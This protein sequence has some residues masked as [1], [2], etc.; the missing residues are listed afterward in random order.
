MPI[1]AVT[2]LRRQSSRGGYAPR[3]GGASI[4]QADIKFQTK[5]KQKKDA[6]GWSTNSRSFQSD[7]WIQS[8]SFFRAKG[9]SAHIIMLNNRLLTSKTTVAVLIG[10]VPSTAALCASPYL[11]C[12]TQ[13]PLAGEVLKVHFITDDWYLKQAGVDTQVSV[14]C[15]A[16]ECTG[17]VFELYQDFKGVAGF[18]AV[19]TSLSPSALAVQENKGSMFTACAHDVGIGNLDLCVSNFW[20]TAERRFMTAF[21]SPFDLETFYLWTEK[22]KARTLTTM[23]A[24]FTTELWSTLALIFVLI[25]ATIYAFEYPAAKFRIKWR[26]R[27]EAMLEKG[28]RSKK[29][30]AQANKEMEKEDKEFHNLLRHMDVWGERDKVNTIEGKAMSILIGL[31]FFVVTACYTANL[32]TFLNVSQDAPMYATRAEFETE[33][34]TACVLT[35]LKGRVERS[36]PTLDIL[37]LPDWQSIKA[38]FLGGKCSGIVGAPSNLP[39]MDI[40]GA[41]SCRLS[42]TESLFDIRFG[43]PIA[44]KYEP[45]FRCALSPSSL[46]PPPPF[47]PLPSSSPSLLP[48][49]PHSPALCSPLPSHTSAC[50]L[51][52]TWFHLANLSAHQMD[53]IEKMKVRALKQRYEIVSE[54]GVTSVTNEDDMQLGLD[55]LTLFLGAI[56]F[57]YLCIVIWIFL[58]KRRW[59]KVD[60]ARKN[61]TFG[62][63]A[64]LDT[65]IAANAFETGG[66]KRENRRGVGVV[67]P[68]LGDDGDGA[69][70]QGYPK[71]PVSPLCP[72]WG[73]SL[74]PPSPPRG[75]NGRGGL[76]LR[77]ESKEERGECMT[78]G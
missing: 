67:V 30:T 39:A 60:A 13:R 71:G 16:E 75:A 64:M 37:A 43:Q 46:F 28:E 78:F 34:Q 61:S 3:P 6:K 18:D 1:A 41:F 22:R 11:N 68:I 57:I 38:A 73:G 77:G 36:Y 48:R 44:H 70:F 58:K 7:R 53:A 76:L 26:E 17:I 29:L 20:E 23:F 27:Q 66:R 35:G 31:M 5:Q 62:R 42:Q 59:K 9:C 10:L 72:A 40:G 12:S 50:T 14:D 51:S 25:K 56:G 69:S 21:S 52:L 24:P 65:I 55:D 32:V 45:L 15:I 63:V 49:S 8:I 33:E 4:T 54:C 74:L 19:F 2:A 47:F